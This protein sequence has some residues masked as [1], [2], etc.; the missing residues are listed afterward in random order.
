MRPR[1]S[2]ASPPSPWDS[3]PFP[4]SEYQGYPL[5]GVPQ[6]PTEDPLQKAFLLGPNGD[7]YQE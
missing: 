6:N 5:I 2:P 1:C 4:V 3:P 7:A